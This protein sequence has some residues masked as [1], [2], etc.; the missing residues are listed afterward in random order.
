MN[1]IAEGGAI[2]RGS[3]KK[4]LVNRIENNLIVLNI[5]N[6]IMWLI[7]PWRDKIHIADFKY[8]GQTQFDDDDDL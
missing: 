6:D 7:A 8:M 2:V 4:I 1:L 3:S 5:T